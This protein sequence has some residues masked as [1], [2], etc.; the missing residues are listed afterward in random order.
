MNLKISS[1]ENYREVYDYSVAEP[2]KFWAEIAD[3]FY[4][5]KKWDTVLRWNF[6]DPDVKWFEGAKLNITENCLDRHLEKNGDTPAIIWESND[7]E[8]AH[9]VLTYTQL[10]D[11]VCQFANVLK[12]NGVKKGDRVC[13]YL[14][15][16]PELA[17]AVLACAR[18]GAIHSVIFGGFSAQSIADRINDAQCS[19]VIT[20]DG[21]FRG[22]KDI[23]L[24]EVIDDALVQCRSVNRVIVLTR[25]RTPV[26]MIKGRDVWWEDEI[27]KVETQGNPECPAEEM[28]AE[29]VLFVLYTSGSTGKPKGVVHTCGGY[30]VYTGYTFANV[31]QYEPGEVYFCTADIGWITGHSYI[32]YGPLSQGATTLMFEGVPTWPGPDRFWQIIDKFNVNILY[33]A[34]TAIRSLMSFGDEP[35]QGKDLSSLKKLGSVGE[36]INEEAW[37]WFHDKI[38]KGKCPIADTWWQTETGGLMISPIAGITPTK[39]GYATLPLPGIQPC[40]V[41]ENGNEIEGNGVSGNLC[42]KFPWPGMLR[43]TYGDHERCRQT[44]FSAYQDMYFTG[45]GCLRD[46]D[47][48]YR[49]TGRVDDVLNVS[50]HR[51]G[52]AEVENAINMHADVVESAVVGY[53]HSIKGQGIY[54]YVILGSSLHNEVD[55]VQKDILKTVTRLIGAIAKPDKIQFVSGLPKTRSGKIMRRILRKIAEGD[56]SNLGDTSTLLDPGVVEE[57]REGALSKI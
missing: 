33:T 16:V 36:P 43:T 55:L 53:P 57:I 26:S 18:I 3:S 54:A 48:Y 1:F 52:T 37:H 20:A 2:E 35:I 23:P 15:M 11:K 50:G 8:E 41:D 28:D 42:V 6:S 27:K 22:V 10:H 7:P 47:G 45:D 49:I 5:R 9:R 24:K 17:I 39:P 29:D 4:W 56:T 44:Y 25:S 19:V 14:P 34:P 51:I 21:G 30:M 40:L 12:N 38:G 13:L 31:F 32:V 46:E